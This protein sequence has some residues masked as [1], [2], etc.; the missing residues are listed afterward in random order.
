M[1]RRSA[2]VR[3]SLSISAV[4]RASV[5]KMRNYRDKLRILELVQFKFR[6]VTTLQLLLRD[7]NLAPGAHRP[8]SGEHDAHLRAASLRPSDFQP[9]ACALGELV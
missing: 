4:H 2:K 6:A 7:R 8:H 3:L 9:R 1:A 5:K